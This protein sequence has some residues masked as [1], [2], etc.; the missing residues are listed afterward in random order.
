MTFILLL[1]VHVVLLLIQ[2]VNLAYLRSYARPKRSTM[3]SVSILIPARNEASNLRR[4]LPSIRRQ[5][6][7]NFDVFVYDDDSTDAT[8]AV[9]T[10]FGFDPRV[11]GI[12]GGGPRTGWVG[13]VHALYEA[14]KHAP[15]TVFLFLD[16][17]AE[18]C[19]PFALRRLVERFQ[20]IGAG[21]VLSGFTRL[22]GGGRL[23][24][25]LVPH[26]VLT[27]WPLPLT[28]VVRSRYVSALNGQC[29]MIDRVAYRRL[30]PHRR[31]AGEVL[32][33]V[34]IGRYLKSKGITPRLVDVQSEVVVWMYADWHDAWRG[35]RKNAYLLMGG[36][37]IPFVLSLVAY[38]CVFVAAPFVHP[39]LL[40]TLYAMKLVSDRASGMP[41]WVT[42]MAPISFAAGVA[43]QIDSALSHWTRRVRWKDRL[44]GT[45]PSS[46][47]GT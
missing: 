47:H 13:K 36:R 14:A 39:A 19:D 41:L 37:P 28:H 31:V 12:R 1:A 46:T 34:A 11:H 15:G 44:V 8:W 42:L 43:L 27:L 6:Y 23:F 24:V 7:P 20:G 3:P 40:A 9:I 32:E 35:F 18:L 29:W 16:A 22:R 10:S 2:G 30:E 45:D 17:E 26:S 33:D 5:E 21:G 38:A 4:L 25:S